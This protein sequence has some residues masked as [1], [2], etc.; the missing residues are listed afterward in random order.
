MKGKKLVILVALIG[1]LVCGITVGVLFYT[2]VLCFHDWASATCTEPVTCRICGKTDGSPNGHTWEEATC[3][4]PETCAICGEI[5]GGSL[6]HTVTDWIIDKEPTCSKEGAKHGKCERCGCSIPES[7][8]KLKHTEGELKIDREPVINSDATVTPGL[9]VLPCT[10]CGAT[11]ETE[12]YT[13]ELT[14]NQASCLKKAREVINM[15]HPGPDY[16]VETLVQAYRFD[17]EDAKFA[18]EYCGADWK[19]QC[20]LACQELIGQGESERMII[21]M[22]QY[23]DFT[24]E[25]IENALQKTGMHD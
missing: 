23:Y 22:L 4:E 9:K 16:L 1:I 8:A 6:G 3:A 12:E 11:I 20:V 2:H 18:L 21:Q 24:D 15:L 14:R 13:I 17:L 7:I 10:V 19:E 25:Q 5:K